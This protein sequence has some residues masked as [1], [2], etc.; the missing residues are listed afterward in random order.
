M[1]EDEDAIGFHLV[2]VAGHPVTSYVRLMDA[3]CAH[4]WRCHHQLFFN[5]AR[6]APGPQPWEWVWIC[7]RCETGAD[8]AAV[9]GA[10]AVSDDPRT[11]QA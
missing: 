9:S 2:R 6:L 5:T 4:C 8:R 11:P 7:D 3:P 1:I 10:E